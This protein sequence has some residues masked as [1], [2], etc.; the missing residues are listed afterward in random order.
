MHQTAAPSIQAW[1][2]PPLLACEQA[3][4]SPCARAPLGL[5][6]LC[7]QIFSCSL[8][9]KHSPGRRTAAAS[10]FLVSGGT[11]TP[12][13]AIPATFFPGQRDRKTDAPSRKLNHQT[14][15]PAFSKECWLSNDFSRSPVLFALNSIELSPNNSPKRD[16]RK[17]IFP[18]ITEKNC[19]MA[20]P[21]LLLCL[22]N[23]IYYSLPT[24]IY[25]I[26]ASN[27]QVTC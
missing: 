14:V 9:K 20:R 1:T 22:L 15:C 3:A 16:I 11:P 7:P 23:R 10:C 2:A 12:Q 24:N 6:P 26:G 27:E 25:Q 17:N 4:R 21:V 8:L 5:K 19:I 18:N 13:G